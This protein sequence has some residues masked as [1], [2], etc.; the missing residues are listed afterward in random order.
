M[1]LRFLI[2]CVGFCLTLAACGQ[3]PEARQKNL[4]QEPVV[5]SVHISA[6]T[7]E[8]PPEDLAFL[9]R[10]QVTDRNLLGF[11]ELTPAPAERLV[12]AMWYMP[13]E[14]QPMLGSASVILTPNA[15][16]TRF[17]LSN[18]EDWK[19]TPLL[20][21]VT[22]SKPR[23][24]K[25]VL[26]SGS[27]QVY[28]GMDDAAVTQ[29]T[30]EYND[31]VRR[32]TEGEEALQPEG[33]QERELLTIAQEYLRAPSPILALRVDL[34]GDA[35]QDDLFLDTRGEP[36]FRRSRDPAI[37]LTARVRQFVALNEKG[38]ALLLL[39]EEGNGSGRVLRTQSWPLG[40]PL[41][42]ASTPI[43]LTVS[44][45]LRFSLSWPE[46]SRTCSIIVVPREKGFQ[47]EAT[48]AC[49]DPSK[50]EVPPQP[51]NMEQLLK[52]LT[53]E[54]VMVLQKPMNLLGSVLPE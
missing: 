51:S 10:Y 46:R 9:D 36:P 2:P 33:A 37:L 26:G 25:T 4:P 32:M 42:S 14:R 29:Y 6:G 7:V 8:T 54:I 12:R 24:K 5:R 22:V 13:D 53:S 41:P 28:M 50:P 45:S 27:V 23:S 52:L 38:V 19:P 43:T 3:Q 47:Q 1:R 44:P 11:V 30:S 31:W 21:R 48:T 49:E 16:L 20:L 17:I 34:N 39:R 40:A 18:P 15:F 35:V